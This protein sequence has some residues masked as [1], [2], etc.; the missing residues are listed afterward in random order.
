MNDPMTVPP[1][2]VP[3][4]EWCV[5]SVVIHDGAADLATV[6]TARRG[7]DGDHSS[8]SF[9]WPRLDQRDGHPLGEATVGPR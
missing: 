7:H 3:Q 8:P 5:S 1:P 9:R 6:C 4:R 2:P